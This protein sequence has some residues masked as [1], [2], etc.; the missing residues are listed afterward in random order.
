MTGE[1][2]VVKVEKGKTFV[3]ISRQSA[4]GKNCESCNAC[5]NPTYVTEVQNP[6]GAC[7]GDRVLLTLETGKVLGTAF[8][9]YLAPILLAFA[10]GFAGYALSQSAGITAAVVVPSLLV[11]VI[12]VRICNRRSTLHSV[13]TQIITE[14]NEAS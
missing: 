12:A 10:V 11:W 14:R 6:L 4:C 2:R 13:I 3:E 9:L 5:S 1:G 8:L 7:V